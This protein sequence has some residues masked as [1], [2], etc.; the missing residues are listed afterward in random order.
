MIIKP[1]L[2]QCQVS[3]KMNCYADLIHH[4][5][6]I[7]DYPNDPSR[8]VTEHYEALLNSS[9]DS[10]NANRGRWFEVCI[11]DSCIKAGIDEAN[12]EYSV[13]PD[14]DLDC[15]IDIVLYPADINKS[16]AYIQA[17]TSLRERWK[18]MDREASIV[19][20]IDRRNPL[21][22]GLMYNE[23]PKNKNYTIEKNIRL[24][25]QKE[26]KCGNMDQIITVM[27]VTRYNNI[28]GRFL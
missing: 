12:I 28:I 17:K 27:D 4:T 7:P 5:Y 16:I 26:G 3:K 18:I 23:Y 13:W 10:G 21:N 1:S 11:I 14:R 24:A 6:H 25:E 19:R 8:H 9:L 20:Q 2:S 22:I 15:E